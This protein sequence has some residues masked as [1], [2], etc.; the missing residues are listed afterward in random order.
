M[1]SNTIDAA[2]T[3]SSEA[4]V[5]AAI[6]GWDG[7]II[8][9]FDETLLLRN[10]TEAFLDCAAPSLLAAIMLRLLDIL[11]PWRWAGGEAVRDVWRVRA[12]RLLFPGT[13]ARW[14]RRIG[15]L[16]ANE[17]LLTA[18]RAR[19]QPFI[20]ASLGFAPLIRPVLAAWGCEAVRL[21]ACELTR[22][23]RERG[24]L[25]LIEAAIGADA[26]A[27]AMVI[28][29]SGADED[30]L[31]RCAKPC[32]TRWQGARFERA[33]RWIYL[34]GDYLIHVKRPLQSGVFRRLASDDLLL[35]MLMAAPGLDVRAL[36][37]IAALFFS[38]WAIY[39]I[40]Y[41]EN[42]ICAVRLEADPVISAAFDLFEGENFPEQA[43]GWAL[44][45]GLL[46]AALLAGRDFAAEGAKWLTVLL[47][48]R[49]VFWLYNRIDKQSRVWLYLVLHGFRG[50]AVMVVAPV[51]I[52]G[53]LAGVAQIFARWQEYF[54]Y[55]AVPAGGAFQWRDTPVR[56]VQLALFL[57]C[58]GG[59]A[60]AGFDI[61]RW[62]SAALLAWS[63]LLARKDIAAAVKGIHVLKMQRAPLARPGRIS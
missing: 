37:G 1:W 17:P 30:V 11:A 48:L 10:A 62:R 21:V 26:L 58:L 38:L 25:A 44:G 57:L 43:W 34:P 27:E 42:D 32:L 52:V 29:D 16:P 12:V 31:A 60:M 14:V 28:T 2:G 15:E 7:L 45:L 51:A 46:G 61:W 9:D 22:R 8:A 5:L 19:R 13:M 59:L 55:R 54:L 6:G 39:E 35:W 40:G 24:K 33:L 18:L 23:D 50:L 49:A 36:A 20:I 47:A 3:G 63:L 4:E 53:M 56:M 41:W